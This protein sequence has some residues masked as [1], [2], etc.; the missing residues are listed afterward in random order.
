MPPAGHSR[1][2]RRIQATRRKAAPSRPARRRAARRSCGTRARRR[3][4]AARPSRRNGRSS[5]NAP[6]CPSRSARP[7]DVAEPPLVTT[8]TVHVY[9]AP[10]RSGAASVPARRRT[11][12]CG[13]ASCPRRASSRLAPSCCQPRAPS[14]RKR[15]CASPRDEAASELICQVKRGAGESI[16]SGSVR[17]SVR[18]PPI[19]IAPEAVA[20][21]AK[22]A[23]TCLR[24]T[25]FPRLWLTRALQLLS[26][27]VPNAANASSGT[28]R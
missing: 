26:F 15:C 9:A 23:A 18:I 14:S 16:P 13:R 12:C 24:M 6:A 28:R 8:L 10:D 11:L 20:R 4:R 1:S 2:P 7:A 21:N 3:S 19:T 27:L 25:G 5:P 17:Y 22:S